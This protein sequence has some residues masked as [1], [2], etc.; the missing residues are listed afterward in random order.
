[1]VEDEGDEGEKYIGG[2]I[3]ILVRSGGGQDA[4][5]GGVRVVD[6]TGAVVHP[7]FRPAVK[8]TRRRAGQPEEP[9][10]SGHFL[11][12]TV[13]R[14]VGQD[15]VL[16]VKGI[17]EIAGRSV[18]RVRERC[19]G[20]RGVGRSGNGGRG[21]SRGGGLRRQDSRPRQNGNTNQNSLQYA[22]HSFSPPSGTTITATPHEDLST[23]NPGRLGKQPRSCCITPFRHN[24]I[25]DLARLCN[26]L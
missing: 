4:G 9:E 22:S 21:G 2:A 7:V 17:A 20:W 6:G 16:L 5:I 23:T 25:N 24:R 15:A 11:V 14:H 1:M 10:A 19:W 12:Q 3:I 18:K 26:T 13:T 8:R